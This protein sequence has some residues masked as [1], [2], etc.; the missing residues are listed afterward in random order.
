M[1]YRILN[2]VDMIAEGTPSVLMASGLQTMSRQS[3]GPVT[4]AKLRQRANCSSF[5][6]DIGRFQL[7]EVYPMH[8][9]VQTRPTIYV[10]I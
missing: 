8:S 10:I 4:R 9:M 1:T 2:A 7:R 6:W 5:G 3:L